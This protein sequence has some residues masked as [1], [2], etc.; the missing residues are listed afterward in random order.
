ML[1]FP[2]LS[3][4][5]ET[6]KTAIEESGNVRVVLN[7]EVVR[8]KRGKNVKVYGRRTKGTDH[9][10]AVVEP[11]DEIREEEF[12]ELI[13]AVDADSCMMILG[14]DI[15]WLESKVLGNVKV[16]L[17]FDISGF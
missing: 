13:M 3:L 11:E 9:N 14:D 8:I 6:W 5:Y 4:L 10:Q 15:G 16:W 1:A 17:L 7:Y 12:D 2:R